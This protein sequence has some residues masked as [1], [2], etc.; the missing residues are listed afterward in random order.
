MLYENNML[1]VSSRVS[2]CWILFGWTTFFGVRVCQDHRDLCWGD[3]KQ[4]REPQ[5]YE[6]L[7]YHDWQTKTRS[8]VDSWNVRK[9]SPKMLSTSNERD[10]V[11]AYKIYCEKQPKNMM[12]D[13]G[14]FCLGKNHTKTDG[15]KK[16]WF[17]LA[18]M[19]ITKLIHWWKRWL[20]S[21]HQQR[22]TH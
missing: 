13:D 22:A 9:V 15:S 5:G 12:A 6:Y 19:G 14:P 1:G 16:H 4:S 8:G 10:P 21:K 11:V 17:K 2:H 18:P 3:V 20:Q 7:A